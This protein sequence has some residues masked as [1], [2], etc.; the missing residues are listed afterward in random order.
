[1]F[2]VHPPQYMSLILAHGQEQRILAEKSRSEEA[3]NRLPEIVI[4]EIMNA[5]DTV[6]YAAEE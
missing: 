5:D 4:T 1:M 3:K 2:S 6:F